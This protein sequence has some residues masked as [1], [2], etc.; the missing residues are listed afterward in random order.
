[1][2]HNV[3]YTCDDSIIQH[4]QVRKKVHNMF[5]ICGR[6][7]EESREGDGGEKKWGEEQKGDGGEK[8]WVG[9]ILREASLQ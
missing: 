8:K 3:M 7:E 1:M 2:Q 4:P 5:S 9:E 6:G